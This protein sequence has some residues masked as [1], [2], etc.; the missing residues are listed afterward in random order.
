[1]S[2]C[3][4]L[5]RRKYFVPSSTSA[6]DDEKSFRHF[7]EL[8]LWVEGIYLDEKREETQR[9]GVKPMWLDKYCATSCPTKHSDRGRRSNPTPGL[10]Q[11]RPGAC[12]SPPQPFWV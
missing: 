1:M 12:W 10:R 5:I 2:I 6:R 8:G 9:C 4:I 11:Q 7:D 3:K